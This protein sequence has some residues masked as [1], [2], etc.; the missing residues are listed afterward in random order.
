M[1][2]GGLVSAHLALL[3]VGLGS[4]PAGSPLPLLW[5]LLDPALV[6]HQTADRCIRGQWTQF[7]ILFDQNGRIVDMQQVAPSLVLTVLPLEREHQLGVEDSRLA[8]ILS[9]FPPKAASGSSAFL[10]R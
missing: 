7:G 4:D 2:V 10:A 8:G 5:F 6:F 9:F 3:E 1:D